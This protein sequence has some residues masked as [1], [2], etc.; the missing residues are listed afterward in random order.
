MKIQDI[1]DTKRGKKKVKVQTFN[2][3]DTTSSKGKSL[4]DLI[5][6]VSLSSVIYSFVVQM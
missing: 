5:L 3:Q 6:H 2:G 1:F 4:Y